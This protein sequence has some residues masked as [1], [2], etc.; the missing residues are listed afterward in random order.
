MVVGEF[1]AETVIFISGVNVRVT[2]LFFM[3]IVEGFEVGEFS[4]F[5]LS[6]PDNVIA[7]PTASA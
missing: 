3:F 1:V 6:Q 4:N 5:I 7:I 2:A